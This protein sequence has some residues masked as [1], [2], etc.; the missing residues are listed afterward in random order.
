MNA[1]SAIYLDHNASAPLRPEARAAVIA[2]LSL[3]ANPS[4]VHG[5][6]RTA[7]KALEAAREAIADLFEAPAAGLVFTSGGTE[8]N[9]L[10]LHGLG[11]ALGRRVVVGATEHPS[12]LQAVAGATILP[13][14]G[15]GL[16]DPAALAATLAAD[17]RPALVS[18]MLANNETG[19]I[20]PI[21]EL[22]AIAAA[23]GALFHTDA[24]QAAG[25]IPLSFRTLGV[26]ALTLS[27]HKLGGP[28]GAG[29]LLLREGLHLPALLRG[30]GQERGRRGGTEPLPAIL[31]FAAAAAAAL[32]GM[33]GRMAQLAAWRDALEAEALR[34]VPGARVLGGGAARL[35]NTSC[36]AMPGVP[37]ATQV[38]AFDLAGIAVSAGSACSSGKVA[39][40]H[41][42]LAMGAG[43]AAGEAIRV[44]FGW[45]S[46]AHD[47][48]SFLDAWAALWRRVGPR[49]A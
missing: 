30:G 27:A 41:A 42:L 25:R 12:V 19:V 28:L 43:A 15:R 37:A 31:G 46:R 49:A 1:S 3:D 44:S 36:L 17:P 20:A 11:P 18:V 38:M 2:A 24:A 13:V 10:A 4:S 8:A 26:D 39:A 32:A 14:D 45:T 21:P 23:H 29:A 5:P 48:T 6:G 35:P 33:D 40:S 22:A 16:P 9:A 34:L 7:R 47:V